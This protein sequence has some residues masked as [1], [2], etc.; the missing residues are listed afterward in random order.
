LVEIELSWNDCPDIKI[1][2]IE[3]NTN[4]ILL[5]YAKTL[6]S[7]YGIKKFIDFYN[8][9]RR[10]RYGLGG[11]LPCEYSNEYNKIHE[12]W[13]RRILL[14]GVD[15]DYV[16][17][18]LKRVQMFKHVYNRMEGLPIS[19]ED[20]KENEDRVLLK[21]FDEGIAYKVGCLQE[22]GLK[23]ERMGFEKSEEIESYNFYSNI[24][25]NY[26]K[27]NKNRWK[28]KKGIF[29]FEK[30]E[31]LY[32]DI[33][34]PDNTED[35]KKAI[36]YIN[37]GFSKWKIEVEGATKGWHGI[38]KGIYEYQYWLDKNVIYY[39]FRYKDI[40]VGLVIYILPDKK[41]THQIINK[42]VGRA[43]Y[44][45]SELNLTEKELVEFEWLKKRLNAYI[46]YKTIQDLNSRG[47]VHGYFGGAFSMQSLRK[48]KQIMNDKEIGHLIYK[49]KESN[50]N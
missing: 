4:D 40:P 36:K 32:F 13:Q 19:I 35:D 33:L 50:L 31:N 12:D 30:M 42:T 17:V 5:D 7:E 48:Y 39:M 26:E 49:L 1:E 28:H 45:E 8:H 9:T 6:G 20:N 37:D 34:G 10:E 27:I 44:D 22:E 21:L 18:V 25:I 3:N 14:V 11:I 2:E 47:L 24:P 43:V 29:R 15:E 23:L 38:S 46:H 41:L 16:I